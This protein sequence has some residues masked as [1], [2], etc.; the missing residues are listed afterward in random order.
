MAQIIPVVS[1][2]LQASIRKLLPSQNGFGEDLQAQNVIVPIID[3]TASAEGSSIGVSLQQAIN[4]GGSTPYSIHNGSLALAS[5][6][7][8]WRFTGTISINRGSAAQSGSLSISDGV[9]T[10]IVYS[11]TLDII[12]SQPGTVSSAYDLIFYLNAGESVTATA[13]G[14]VYVTGSYRQ[15]ASST[16]EL[17]NP[18]GFTSE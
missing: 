3:L 15:V 5:N 2:A 10:K 11:Q 6:A 8:F 9:T 12:S 7:G 1:E 16:G 14:N 4:F 17:V 18:V 13:D